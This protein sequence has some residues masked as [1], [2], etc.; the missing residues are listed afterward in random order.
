[1][2]DFKNK[3]TLDLTK[4]KKILIDRN[5]RFIK[6]DIPEALKHD[7]DDSGWSVCDLPHDWSIEVPFDRDTP[8]GREQ[9]YLPRWDIGWYRKSF[10]LNA[11]D[12]DR[13]VCVQFDGI[14]SN[15]DVWING[16]HL[17]KRPYGYVSFEYDLTPYLNFG[18]TNTLSVR[19]DNSQPPADRWYS[20]AGIYRHVWLLITDKCCVSNWGTFVKV[21]VNSENTATVNI[22]TTLENNNEVSG[23]CVISTVIKDNEG[24]IEDEIETE[25]LIPAGEEIELEQ[26]LTVSSPNLWD[27][28]NPVLY[29][30]YSTIKVR[31]EIIDDYITPFGI[32]RIDFD[33]EK[34]MFLNGKNIKL[35]GV[36]LHHE[37]GCLGAAVPDRALE[38]RLEVLKSMGCNAI[39]TSHNPPAPE[40]LDLCDNM[41]FLV[42]D[43]AFDKWTWDKG[44]YYRIFEEWWERDLTSM[45]IRDRNHPSVIIWS[46]G[47]EVE[48]QSSDSMLKIT[49]MLV[50]HVHK[51]DPSRPVT[52]ALEPH[53]GSREIMKQPV[54]EK[55]RLTRLNA[56]KVDILGLNYH[57]FWYRYY[58]EANIG[59]LAIATETYPFYKWG[60]ND[61]FMFDTV[62]PWFDVV[63]NDFVIGQFVWAGFDYLGESAGWPS[64]GWS[65]GLINTCGF[66]KARSYFYE[67]VW[68]DK[69]MVSIAVFDDTIENSYESLHWTWP[70]IVS[71]WTLP[72]FE[73]QLV[74]LVTYTNCEKVELFMN[75]VSMGTKHLSEFPNHMIIWHIPYMAGKLQAFG[76][77]NN[78]P[79]CTFELKTAGKPA[80]IELI[81]D[82]T[83]I[84][85]DGRDVCHVEV[86]VID[87]EGTIVPYA[88]NEITFDLAGN[89]RIL[90]LDNGN[91]NSDEPYKGNKRKTHCGKCLA[92]LQS[93]GNEGEL[94]LV[95][96]SHGL[97]SAEINIRVK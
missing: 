30:A 10:E 82:R 5:W 27:I 70:R 49:E 44:H 13:K 96:K 92:V 72:H 51:L 95:S 74:K 64:K 69:P 45:I 33:T 58:K 3:Y 47:N 97:E 56:E 29:Q 39:R 90:G 80:K 71:S 77:N 4:R 28:E 52:C 53:V 42:M 91:L 37:A 19:A 41:G 67:C 73:R 34:G 87:V 88:D 94:T 55:V 66:R 50:G 8:C 9:G 84:S 86:R 6:R 2:R 15:S 36:C 17:G 38:R 18:C 65:A 81:P 24:R 40:L 78:E 63:N 16:H 54:E 21:N 32:R 48:N 89:G 31:D 62:N 35:K 7:F 46:V 75:G 83:S 23:N 43:E 60:S 57:E 59:H 14:Y 68:S 11:D 1:M 85:T 93:D 25:A 26:E 12:K 20:G 76:L 79:V 22:K 61:K